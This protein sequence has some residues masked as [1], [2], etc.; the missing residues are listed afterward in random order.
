V[1]RL[2]ERRAEEA[3]AVFATGRLV[4][5]GSEI[6]HLAERAG[7]GV[8]PGDKGGFHLLVLSDLLGLTLVIMPQE[9]EFHIAQIGDFLATFV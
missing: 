2:Q 8:R 4:S 1:E 3:S 6:M 5:K 7:E 9:F